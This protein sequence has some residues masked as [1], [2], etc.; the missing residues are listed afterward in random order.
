[1]S[2]VHIRQSDIA[3]YPNMATRHPYLGAS[4]SHL[5]HRP[6]ATMYNITGETIPDSAVQCETIPDSAV[7]WDEGVMGVASHWGVPCHDLTPLDTI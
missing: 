3:I 4:H 7:Q 1:M 6:L 2:Y 5:C